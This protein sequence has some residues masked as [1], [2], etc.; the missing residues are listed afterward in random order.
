[1]QKYLGLGQKS[2]EIFRSRS[3]VPVAVNART[4]KIAEEE[5]EVAGLGVSHA[6]D[7][8]GGG[9]SGCGRRQS[10]GGAGV[11][12]G[13]ERPGVAPVAAVACGGGARVDGG[14]GPRSGRRAWSVRAARCGAR[15]GAGRAGCG[16]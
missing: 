6:G 3:R 12:G 1:M 14:G 8:D 10:W 13:A 7:E 16:T 5:N 15:S 11:V 9:R 4:E 2:T